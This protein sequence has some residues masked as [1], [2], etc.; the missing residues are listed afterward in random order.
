MVNNGD[1]IRS[2]ELLGKHKAMFKEIAINLNAD[3]PSDP[4]LRLTWCKE[5][6]DRIEANA[7]ILTAYATTETA[8]AKRF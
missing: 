4:A 1:R 6:I 2:M 8:I 3:I 5:E 7:G